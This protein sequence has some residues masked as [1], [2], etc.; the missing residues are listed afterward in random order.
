M[1]NFSQSIDTK[2]VI[3]MCV[4]KWRY[5]NL[6]LHKKTTLINE[7]R[8]FGYHHTNFAEE[9]PCTKY[10]KFSKNLNFEMYRF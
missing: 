1:S 10:E 9:N 4:E 7:Y 2:K 5:Q 6:L 8:V 3:L